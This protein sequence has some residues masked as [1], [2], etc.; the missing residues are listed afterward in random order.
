M[1]A[2][3]CKGSSAGETT[4]E[5]PQE[6][7]AGTA[8]SASITLGTYKG[9]TLTAQKM[10]VTD[11]MLENQ[12]NYLK[13]VY[14]AEVTDRSAREGDVA[15][16][17]FVGM[18]D[19]V[20]FQ[21]GTGSNF[22]LTLGSGRFID[23]FEAGVVGM[24]PGEEK[25]LDLTFPETY[26]NAELAGQPVVFHVTLNAIKDPE[27]TQIDDALARRVTG[28]ETA[29]L[30]SLKKQLRE[31]LENQQENEWFNSAGNELLAQVIENSEI[32][33]DASSVEEMYTELQ[34]TYQAYAAQ[35]GMELETFLAMYMGTDTEGLKELAEELVKQEM[36]ID[37]II[38]AEGLT[39]TDS[40]RESM[41]RMN[42]FENQAAM[43]LAYGEESANRLF[44]M[45]AAYYYLIENA[46]KAEPGETAGTETNGG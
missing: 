42:S 37:E 30:A 7:A 46:A 20:A 38:K 39:A 14:P 3:G 29:T 22:D 15:N 2:T 31:E 8:S 11:A 33:C 17:D 16:I 18:K 45:G 36:A 34:M 26:D 35:Y 40:Q 44:E 6:T 13:T 21:G 24:R 19:G 28:E 9:L 27:H 12:L 5:T 4:K 43:I 10:E 25:D 1:F 23:G 41:A 32:V